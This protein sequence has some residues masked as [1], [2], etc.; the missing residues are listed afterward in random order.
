MKINK[1]VGFTVEEVGGRRVQKVWE[2]ERES[3]NVIIEAIG[4][5]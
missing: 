4:N 2:R 3:E 1:T 5:N